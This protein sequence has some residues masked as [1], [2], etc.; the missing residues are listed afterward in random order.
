M[1]IELLLYV[2][3][4]FRPR[5]YWIERVRI[6]DWLVESEGKARERENATQVLSWRCPEV[7]EF[8]VSSRKSE[9]GCGYSDVEKQRAEDMQAGYQEAS[10][11]R[12]LQVR[13]WR[14]SQQSFTLSE[15]SSHL[16]FACL[17]H[18]IWVT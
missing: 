8:L 11:Y 16:S 2:R 13:V 12:D 1:F 4:S 7:G 9:E 14:T 5:I 10:S 3:K 17:L 15:M 6:L 18:H